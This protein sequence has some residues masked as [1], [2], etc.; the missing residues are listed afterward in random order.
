MVWGKRTDF[1]KLS[2]TGSFVSHAK[3]SQFFQ[4]SFL[5]SSQQLN[6]RNISNPRAPWKSSK[7][8]WLSVTQRVF[9]CSVTVEQLFSDSVSDLLSH[10]ACSCSVCRDYKVSFDPYAWE[11]NISE[12][13]HEENLVRNRGEGIFIV[14]NCTWQAFVWKQRRKEKSLL[15]SCNLYYQKPNATN[16]VMGT[17]SSV[18]FTIGHVQEKSNEKVAKITF[19]RHFLFAIGFSLKTQ[20]I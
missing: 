8:I 14:L 20:C 15:A 9:I 11:E 10:G 1:E 4:V 18:F 13:P 17:T 3:P 7:N 6:T 5:S 19:F 2:E 12:T 16:S